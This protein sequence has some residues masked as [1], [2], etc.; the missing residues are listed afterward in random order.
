MLKRRALKPLI[1]KN[2]LAILNGELTERSCSDFIDLYRSRLLCMGQLVSL[3]C[4]QALHN[5]MLEHPLF[6]MVIRKCVF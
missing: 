6:G 3:T 5:M 2:L 4:F 1:F